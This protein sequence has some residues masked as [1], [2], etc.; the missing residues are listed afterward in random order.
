MGVYRIV[1][2]LSR[3][4]ISG[5]I[6]VNALVSPWTCGGGAFWARSGNLPRKTG[7]KTIDVL[8][9]TANDHG[10]RHGEHDDHED[11]LQDGL[12]AA[13]VSHALF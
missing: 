3:N 12:S 13:F 7:P 4:L 2:E 6:E 8:V 5:L 11:V 1:Q 9:R 10:H